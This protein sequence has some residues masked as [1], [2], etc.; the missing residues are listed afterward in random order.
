MHRIRNGL[1]APQLIYTMYARFTHD[2]HGCQVLQEKEK[3]EANPKSGP[4]LVFLTC[5]VIVTAIHIGGGHI[6]DQGIISVSILGNISY[7]RGEKFLCQ[8][9]PSFCPCKVAQPFCGGY[10]LFR[11]EIAFYRG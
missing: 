3:N 9:L 5:P 1:L 11:S 7:P 2:L 10:L 4:R 8:K 6:V